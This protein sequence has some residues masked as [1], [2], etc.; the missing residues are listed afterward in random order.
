MIPAAPRAG[1]LLRIVALLP[2]LVLSLLAAPLG[3]EAQQAGKVVRVG[4]LAIAAPTGPEVA[5]LYQSFLRGMRDLGWVE[6]RNLVIEARHVA[7]RQEL[8]PEVAAE[9]VRVGVDVIVAWSPLAVAAAKKATSTIP[10]V[11]LSMGDPVRTGLVTSLARPGGNVTG[12]ANLRTALTGKWLELLKESVPAI[13]RVAVLANPANP[14]LEM[15]DYV[16]EVNVATRSW[17]AEVKF[18]NVGTPQ[19]FEKAFEEMNKWRADGLRVLP[20]AMFWTYRAE[21]V[22]LTAKTRLPAVYWS[23]EYADVGGLVSY[24]P[25]LG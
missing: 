20:D 13:T 17:N 16:Q 21:I 24:A 6:G 7:G 14:K 25:S 1:R 3:A 8:F 5:T 23:T 19:A 11:G 9:L 22:K 2:I 10:I 15:D 12:V 18:F 4:W